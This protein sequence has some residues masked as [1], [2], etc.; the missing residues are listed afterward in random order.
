MYIYVV[1][2]ISESSHY[3]SHWGYEDAATECGAERE[4]N[5]DEDLFRVCVILLYK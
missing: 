5:T 1:I 4:V 3:Y 2:S